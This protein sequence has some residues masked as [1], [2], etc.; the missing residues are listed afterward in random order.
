MGL[1]VLIGELL[2][3]VQDLLLDDRGQALHLL[4]KDS[5][6]HLD[7]ANTAHWLL[8]HLCLRGILSSRSLA[9]RHL[10]GRLARV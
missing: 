6:V 8:D 5:F 10:L 3:V 1:Q 4:D 7:G 9:L 2:E